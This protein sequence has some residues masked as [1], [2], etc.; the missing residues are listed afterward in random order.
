MFYGNANI[1]VIPERYSL[2]ENVSELEFFQT[3][4]ENADNQ[5]LVEEYI[6]EGANTDM[7]NKFRELSK[8]YNNQIDEVKS[9]IRKDDT[10][11]AASKLA[12]AKK[13]V[14]QFKKEIKA[15]DS[16]VG[17]AAL[18]SLFGILY[19]M[20]KGFEQC[21]ITVLPFHLAGKAFPH[22]IIA[23]YLGFYAGIYTKLRAI[24]FSV[25]ETIKTISN[26]IKEIKHSENKANALNLYRTALLN[27][28]GDLESDIDQ[29]EKNI[30]GIKDGKEF[31]QKIKDMF[32]G[33][34]K[35]DKKKKDDNK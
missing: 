22:S 20:S 28:I 5:V 34:G 30:K 26:T 3:V 21:V 18:G 14:A 13:T 24:V 2:L 27:S 33:R 10:E 1:D 19:T 15:I 29:Y 17:S 12:E 16:D 31:K 6:E 9:A 8:K 4:V 35:E 25:T 11:L 23:N 7:Y 32:K